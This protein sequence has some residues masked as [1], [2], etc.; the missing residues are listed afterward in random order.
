MSGAEASSGSVGLAVAVPLEL[1]ILHRSSA[2]KR[3][4]PDDAGLRQHASKKQRKAEADNLQEST[5]TC[6]S[7]SVAMTEEGEEHPQGMD[8]LADREYIQE[9]VTGRK[10]FRKD[11]ITVIRR[12]QDS[13]PPSDP[14][15]N[16][17]WKIEKKQLGYVFKAQFA[18]FGPIESFKTIASPSAELVEQIGCFQLCKELHKL[19][20][21]DFGLF[22][23]EEN[24]KAPDS[25]HNPDTASQTAKSSN[26]TRMYARRCPQFFTSSLSSIPR[27]LYPL[28]V[29]PA[30]FQGQ[31]YAPLLMLAGAPWPRLPGFKVFHLA[32]SS[33]VFLQRAASFDIGHDKLLLLHQYTLRVSRTAVNKDLECGL[34]SMPFF[35]APLGAPWEAASPSQA[36]CFD[37]PAVENH[38]HWGEI[39]QA[40]ENWVTGLLDGEANLT[41]VMVNDCAVQDRAVE[42]TNRFSVVSV[43]PDINPMSKP[44]PGV[45]SSISKVY[46]ASAEIGFS[47]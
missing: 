37:L 34:E 3:S 8:G 45:V 7:E 9:P 39:Q 19:G 21:L 27:R 17:S 35:F 2:K 23:W 30:G 25:G 28:I 26:T 31:K 10:L 12:L 11:A 5:D 46:C 33:I 41:D 42:F 24:N 44:E 13:L 29:H 20:V 47:A 40:N 16:P 43:R 6:R 14:F 36:H 1:D 32:E 22:P 18:D 38:I 4:L 15:R